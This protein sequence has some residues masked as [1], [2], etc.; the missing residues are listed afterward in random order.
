MSFQPPAES[1]ILQAYPE[2]RTL[3][4]LTA[5]GFKAVYRAQTARGEEAFKLLFLPASGASDREQGIR[6]EQLGRVMREVQLL[7][8][9]TTPEVVKLGS[10]DARTETIAGTEYIGYSEEWLDGPDLWQMIRG[11]VAAPLPS[12]TECRQLLLSLLRAIRAI[13]ELNTIHRDIKPGNVVK[14]A[15]VDRPFVLLDLGIAYDVTEASLT[16]EASQRMPPATY[17]YFAPEMANLDFR[18]RLTYRTDLYTAGLTV[19]EYATREHPIARQGDDLVMTLS[20]AIRAPPRSL[21]DL[22]PEISAEFSALIDQLLK[23]QPMLRGN[24][25]QLIQR[26]ENP[27]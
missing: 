22:R 2:L 4:F 10:I 18:D 1:A 14:L 19:F 9:V 15:R 8:R 24:L 26:L 21:R 3:Q 11:P 25:A 12:E 27:A 13:S 5:G 6:R 17:R 23:K 20:R 16:Y 7:A